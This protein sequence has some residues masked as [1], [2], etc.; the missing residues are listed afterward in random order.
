MPNFFSLRCPR[1]IVSFQI[2][3]FPSNMRDI[4]IYVPQWSEKY[5]LKCSLIK[6]TSSWRYKRI[7]IWTLNKQPK[8]FLPIFK[9]FPK[10]VS[11]EIQKL[12]EYSP[13][14]KL[15]GYSFKLCQERV[16]KWEITEVSKIFMV[17]KSELI[18]S[19]VQTCG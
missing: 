13:S 3:I 7:I 11:N 8:I 6:H 9:C 15:D 1:S 5:L 14:L 4:I 19:E 10:L 17:L 18:V 2:D 16:D 12:S